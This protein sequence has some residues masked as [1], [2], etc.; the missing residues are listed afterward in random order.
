MACL[1]DKDPV[2]PVAETR[3]ERP[4]GSRHEPGAFAQTGDPGELAGD[5]DSGAG[6]TPPPVKLP[7]R[8]IRRLG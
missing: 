6:G 7:A 3:L 5:G 4:R 1:P 2:A 8:P